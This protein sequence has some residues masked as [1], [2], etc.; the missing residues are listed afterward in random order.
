[1]L[2]D[3]EKIQ[4]AKERLGDENAFWMAEL[5]EL[6]DFDEQNLKACCCFHDEDTPSLIYNPK[7]YT[8]KCFGC[9]RCIDIVSTLQLKKNLTFVEAVQ[10]LFKRAG[11]KYSFGEHRVNTRHQYKYPTLDSENNPMDKVYEYAATRKIS[12]ETIDY[13]GIRSTPDGENIAFNF[14]DDNDSLVMVKYRPA[15]KI[16]KNAKNKESK[17]WCQTGADTAPILFNMNRVDTSMPVLIT[18]GEFDCLAAIEAGFTNAVSVPLGAGNTHWVA[19]CWDWLERCKSIIICA[20]NDSA[21]VKMV[22]DVVYRLGSW[23]TK[24][25]DIPYTITTARG[26][27]VEIK[28]LNEYLYHMGKEATMDLLLNAKDTP[29]ASLVDFSDITEMDMNSIDGVTTGLKEVDEYLT[30]LFCGTLTVLTGT[31]GSGKTSFLSQIICQA[32]DQDFNVWLFSR[33]LP[34]RLTKNWI[35]HVFAGRRHALEFKNT[36]TGK[37]YYNVAHDAFKAISE[38]YKDRLKIYRD[39]YPNDLESIKNSMIDSVRKYNTRLLILDNMMC[40]DMGMDGTNNNEKQ[41]ELINWLIQ[42][43][44]QYHVAVVLVAHPRKMESSSS[45]PDLYSISGTANIANLCHRT[46]ALRRVSPKEKEGELNKK[47]DGWAKKPIKYD[48]MLGIEKDRLM[49]NANIDI[50]LYYDKPSRRFYSTPEEYD[51]HYAW[52]QQTYKD[53]LIYPPDEVDE[54]LFGPRGDK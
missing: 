22:K 45:K 17:T 16:R 25:V 9:G 6:D 13:C 46:L 33:E 30:K 52:D 38:Y 12:K 44:K 11:I 32:L 36:K 3:Q 28:D 14:W 48:V 49:G 29:V 50:G 18:E 8:F 26:K 4:E 19:E 47:G 15:H 35:S 39:D 41:T 27:E 43:S 40:I 7:N 10:E 31:P 42:F 37:P 34:D 20:D 24:I 21:G 2:I 53:T 51:W 1:M 5:L 23:R 54:K